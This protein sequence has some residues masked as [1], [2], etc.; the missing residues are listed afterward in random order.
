MHI[1]TQHQQKLIEL[2]GERLVNY[3]TW[4]L[5]HPLSVTDRSSRQKLCKDIVERNSTI[6]QLDLT[7]IYNMLH[8][9]TA[10]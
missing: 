10:E 9:T 3:Y 7:D 1:K 8:T 4:G 6:I 5:R 2:Q